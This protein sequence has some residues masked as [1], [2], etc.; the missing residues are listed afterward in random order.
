MTYHAWVILASV[1]MLVGLAGT[2]LPVLPGITLMFFIAVVFGF[3]DRFQHLTGLEVFVLFALT[4]FS[5]GVD[6]F[7]GLLGARY[8]GA[9]AKA[10][11]AGVIGFILGLILFPPFGGLIGI[12]AGVLLAELYLHR[13][14]RRALRAA[15]GS[16]IGTLA[17]IVIG[18]VIGVIFLALFIWFAWA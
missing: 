16:L 5:L 2:A 18:V 4:L 7:A 14:Q 9:S 3:A 17:G 6:Y 11:V 12:F 8:G 13:D 10:M 15:S 1:L